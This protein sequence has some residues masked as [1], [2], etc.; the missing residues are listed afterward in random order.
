VRARRLA[1]GHRP[2]GVLAQ[3]PPLRNRPREAHRGPCHRWRCDRL[4]VADALVRPRPAAPVEHAGAQVPQ[5]ERVPGPS[6]SGASS[7]CQ[8]W[9]RPR[10]GGVPTASTMAQPGPPV[11]AGWPV[12][13]VAA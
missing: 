5:A 4:L 11:P 2:V 13:G 8:P 10:S 12:S 3:G 6:G 9:Q 1:A 7:A